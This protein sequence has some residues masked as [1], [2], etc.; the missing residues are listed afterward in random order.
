MEKKAKHLSS[1]AETILEQGPFQDATTV[2]PELPISFLSISDPEILARDI[3]LL[4]DDLN[5][6]YLFDNI[7]FIGH[8]AGALIIIKVYLCAYGE[9]ENNFEGRLFD[10]HKE[11]DYYALKSSREWV[12]KVNRI[13][14]LAGINLGWSSNPALNLL[15]LLGTDFGIILDTLFYGLTK[16]LFI[17]K[18]RRNSFFLTHLRIQWMSLSKSMPIK[19]D[20]GLIVQLLGT[21]DIVFR[22][23][24]KFT[25]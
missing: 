8:S 10:Y 16:H 19:Q 9:I 13:I 4:I 12:K 15:L 14:L 20:R 11:A 2:I 23:G 17:F 1:I 6:N 22:P 25:T 21:I 18:L 7:Y 24:I 3:V 5:D